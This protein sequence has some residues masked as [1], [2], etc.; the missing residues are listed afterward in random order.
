MKQTIG[1]DAENTPV[2]NV[3]RGRSGQATLA[4]EKVK[5]LGSGDMKAVEE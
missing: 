1:N 4:G 5:Y 3:N 2:G